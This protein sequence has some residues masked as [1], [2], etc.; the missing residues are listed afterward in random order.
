MTVSAWRLMCPCLTWLSLV[1]FQLSLA[2]LSLAQLSSA[3]LSSAQL[4]SAWLSSAQLGSAQFGSAQLG[5]FPLELIT[6][7]DQFFCFRLSL[8]QSHVVNK[9]LEWQSQNIPKTKIEFV[10]QML[11]NQTNPAY[12]LPL[13]KYWWWLKYDATILLELIL[14]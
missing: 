14:L 13:N 12:I 10:G 8:S 3:R 6:T 11:H 7:K 4:S 5:K 2:Q 1:T 9:K